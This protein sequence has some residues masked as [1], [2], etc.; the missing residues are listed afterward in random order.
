MTTNEDRQPELDERYGNLNDY[1]EYSEADVARRVD[2]ERDRI[3]A[4]IKD[5]AR[6]ASA[7]RVYGGVIEDACREIVG[8]L[9]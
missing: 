7:D 6:T 9:S 2:A 1:A 3:V 5:F 8:E 4:I